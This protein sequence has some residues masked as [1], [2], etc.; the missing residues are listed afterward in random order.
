MGAPQIVTTTSGH[1]TGRWGSFWDITASQGV[2]SAGGTIAVAIGQSDPAN[3]G[4][5]ITSG[6]RV[7]F[8]SAGVY[9]V[10]FSVQFKNTSATM[11]DAQLWLRKNGT[12]SA[13]DVPDSNSR[14]SV[15]GKHGSTDGHVLGTVNFVMSMSASDYISLMFSA[16]NVAVTIETL[17]ATTGT[18]T[19]PRTPGVILTAVQ[20]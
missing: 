13:D 5:S 4:V 11:Y 3:S 12:T 8:A 10:T 6:D 17:A 14:F 9:S 16:E 18:P 19:V 7:T 2:P 15:T 1:V 20:V